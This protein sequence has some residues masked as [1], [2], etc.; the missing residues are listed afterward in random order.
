[1]E[2][3]KPWG[4][5]DPNSQN[6]LWSRWI[7][8]FMTDAWRAQSP[9]TI[10]DN[11]RRFF[12]QLFRSSLGQVR[13]DLRRKAS[14]DRYQITV[15]IEGPPA[16]DPACQDAA[17]RQFVRDFLKPGF[18]PSARCTGLEVSILAGDRQDGQPRIQLLVMPSPPAITSTTAW[19]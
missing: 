1:M 14:G 2:M 3:S 13:C 19:S 8:H 15:E 12:R 17:R 18:G 16:H 5:V 9:D 10:A 7:F 4:A 6:Q 11:A